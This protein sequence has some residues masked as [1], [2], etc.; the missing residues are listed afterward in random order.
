MLILDEIELYYHPELQQQ[1]LSKL[2]FYI[3]DMELSNITDINMCLLTHS[4]YILSD[5]P[6]NNIL[7]LED[8]NDH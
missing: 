3:K 2:L 5:I 8:G 1:F 4:P 6:S 7:K